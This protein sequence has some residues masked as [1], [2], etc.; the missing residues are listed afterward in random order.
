[1]RVIEILI[2]LEAAGTAPTDEVVWWAES[3]DLAGFSAAAY[4]LAVLRTLV[5]EALMEE[6]GPEF[7]VRE[8]L[9]VEGE[10]DKVRVSMVEQYAAAA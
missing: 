1:M 5:N 2:H 8:R 3:S 9:A 6:F 4:S 10:G 7:A